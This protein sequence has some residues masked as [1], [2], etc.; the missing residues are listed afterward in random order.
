MQ[1]QLTIVSIRR[2]GAH[3]HACW[4]LESDNALKGT[5]LHYIGQVA[6][7]CVGAAEERQPQL[8]VV[9]YDSYS[10]VVMDVDYMERGKDALDELCQVACHN[11]GRL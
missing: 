10:P 4:T 5:V 8:F 1:R 2:D 11:E 9:C 7:N 3:F 6:E